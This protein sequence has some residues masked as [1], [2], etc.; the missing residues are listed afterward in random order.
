M[1]KMYEND[2]IE[3]FKDEDSY[4]VNG[5]DAYKVY[6]DHYA[7][8]IIPDNDRK[9][10]FVKYFGKVRKAHEKRSLYIGEKLTDYYRNIK[11]TIIEIDYINAIINESDLFRVYHKDFI[12]V[13]NT[14]S[15]KYD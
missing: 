8:D 10:L 5:S 14:V 2:N 13:K 6:D 1:I 11:Y 15:D 9:V 12:D 4:Y 3:I 7:V